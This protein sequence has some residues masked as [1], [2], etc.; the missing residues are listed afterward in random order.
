MLDACHTR[1]H[2]S[3]FI[4]QKERLMIGNRQKKNIQH[5]FQEE[6]TGNV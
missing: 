3:K 2:A 4:H 5:A 6:Q 1:G